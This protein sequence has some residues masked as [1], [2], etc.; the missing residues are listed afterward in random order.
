M[1]LK[2]YLEL[3]DFDLKKNFKNL[4][5]NITL[6]FFILNFWQKIIIF[7]VPLD[8]TRFANYRISIS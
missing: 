3:R 7:G 5:L 6:I 2:P 8:I 1:L 4:K